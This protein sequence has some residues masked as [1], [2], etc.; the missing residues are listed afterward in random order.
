AIV[1]APRLLVRL[2]P[3]RGHPLG[4]AWGDTSLVLP[5]IPAGTCYR[6]V[7]SGAILECVRHEE[8]AAIPL[9]EVFRD[10][11]VALLEPI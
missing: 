1:V 6:H 4:T 5:E 3:K 7:F 8:G 11:P 2:T 10:I 9:A